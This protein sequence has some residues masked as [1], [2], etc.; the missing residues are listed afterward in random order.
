MKKLAYDVRDA[1]V[2]Y[3]KIEG[4]ALTRRNH[5]WVGLDN[6][7]GEVESRLIDLGRFRNPLAKKK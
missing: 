5:L 3:E 4:L 1:F 7:G 6:D 2:P